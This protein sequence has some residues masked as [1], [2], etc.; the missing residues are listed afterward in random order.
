MDSAYPSERRTISEQLIP[1]AISY[2][3]ATLKLNRR[4]SPIFID[5]ERSQ[6]CAQVEPQKSMEK[7][8][9][10]DLV[11]LVKGYKDYFSNV[12][13]SAKNCYREYSTDR[14]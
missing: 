8:I 6:G 10:A 13:A 1:A 4:K 9:E 12:L 5:Q 11:L 3:Q 7:G 2:Y 14:Y